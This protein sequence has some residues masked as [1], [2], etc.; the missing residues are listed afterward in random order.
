M[1]LIGKAFEKDGRGTATLIPQESED[2]WHLYNLVTNGDTV[3][4]MTLRKIQKEGSTGSVQT[5]TKKISI[6]IDVKSVEYDAAGNCIRFSGKNAEENQWVKMGAH[7]TVEIGLDQK[8]TIGKDRWDYMFLRQLEEATDV[9][10]TAEVGVV[11]L[12]AGVGNFHLLTA[13]LAKDVHRVS[14]QLPRKRISTTGYDKAVVRFYEQVY[15]GIKDHM[16]LDLVKCVVLAGPGFV[17]DDFLTWMLLKANQ[18]GDTY[19]LQKKSVFIVANTSCVHRQALKELLADDQVQKSISNTKA[20]AHLKA[21]DEFYQ[22]VKNDPDRASYGPKQVKEAIE[23]GAVSVLM[24]VDS[25]FRNANVALRRQYVDLSE[26]VREQGA[27]VHVFSSQHISGEQ[28]AQLG[29]IAALLRFPCPELD[30]IDSD[31]ELD[32]A[33]TDLPEDDD[34]GEKRRPMEEDADAFM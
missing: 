2:L 18:A 7:H 8:L 22:M 27:T 24:V 33:S 32:D 9:H 23:K 10:K 26:S 6:T 3:K 30:E 21:L 34:K 16:N 29:G 11:L 25:L 15:Q 20:A 4:A 13:V 1:K 17:K 14:V 19:V 12:E 28:L 31:A 5:E